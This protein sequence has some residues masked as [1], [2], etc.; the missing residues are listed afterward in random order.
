VWIW[1]WKRVEA[2]KINQYLLYSCSSECRQSQD[3]EKAVELI[4]AT[5]IWSIAYMNYKNHSFPKNTLSK[6]PENEESLPSEESFWVGGSGMEYP[7]SYSAD[8]QKHERGLTN[9]FSLICPYYDTIQK[10]ENFWSELT[11][12]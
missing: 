1:I 8:F 7:A 10:T 6:T 11:C 4:L 3:N 2:L 12:A 9:H 5:M